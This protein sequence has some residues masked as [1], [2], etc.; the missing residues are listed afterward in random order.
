VTARISRL[1]GLDDDR[2]IVTHGFSGDE[3]TVVVEIRD[4]EGEFTHAVHMR[5]DD[6]I[7]L[8]GG[9]LRHSERVRRYPGGG[10]A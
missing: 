8:A 10:D 7:Y 1:V 4:E 6:A 9:L 3:P 2:L 5:P